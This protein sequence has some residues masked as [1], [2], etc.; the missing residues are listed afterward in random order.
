MKGKDGYLGPSNF[1]TVVNTILVYISCTCPIKCQKFNY[2]VK[3]MCNL[4]FVTYFQIAY[5]KVIL[6]Y[7]LSE[8]LESSFKWNYNMIFETHSVNLEALHTL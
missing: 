6:I 7:I 2:W 4:N 5:E 1:K 8:F 3:S